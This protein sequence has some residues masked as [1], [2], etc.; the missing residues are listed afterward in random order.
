MVA[1]ENP[2]KQVQLSGAEKAAA[3]LFFMGKDTASKLADFFTQEEIE[4]FVS[5]AS[6]LKSL[7]SETIVDLVTEFRQNYVNMGV[8]AEAEN[9]SEFFKDLVVEDNGE[10]GEEATEEPSISTSSDVPDIED[11]VSF[12]GSEP[13]Y[14]CVFLLASLDEELLA[15]VFSELDAERRKALFKLYMDREPSDPK[16][17]ALMRQE[18]F[19]SIMDKGEDDGSAKRIEAAAGVMNFLAEETGEE[20]MN[21][22]RSENPEAAEILKKSLFRFSEIVDL[23]KEVRSIVFDGVEPDAMVQALQGADDAMKECVLEVVSQRNRR[24][25]EAELS[26]GGVAEEVTL[27]AQRQISG[28]V[29]AL[30]KEGKISLST[31]T[32]ETA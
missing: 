27:A 9:F 4:K 32:E 29:L 31:S 8:F 28:V 2:G 21:Y 26:R 30:A 20:L 23:S 19:S 14:L 22:I 3:L 10:A 11:I 16:I 1:S 15:N 5:T 18:L 12:L 7:E 25:I 6:A 17:E 13:D 24:M